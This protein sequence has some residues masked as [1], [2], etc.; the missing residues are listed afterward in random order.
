MIGEEQAWQLTARV[1][2]LS[3]PHSVEVALK[4]T[5]SE[6]TRF[7]NNTVHQNVSESDARVCV[8]IFHGQ[9]TGAAITNR[10]EPAGLAAAV[11]KA[12][13][14]ASHGTPDPHLPRMVRQ[15]APAA[16]HAFDPATAT[17][18]PDARAELVG[19]LC[20]Q[21]AGIGLRASGAFRVAAEE[22]AVATSEGTFAYHAGTAADFQTVVMGD[23]SSGWAHA[24]HWKATEIPVPDLGEEA[25]RKAVDGKGPRTFEPQST[26]VVLEPYA[27]ADLVMMLNFVG[28]GAQSVIEGQSWMVDRI[29][30]QAMS[31]QVS[32]WDDGRDSEGLPLAFDFEGVPKQRVD[33]VRAGVVQGP[34]YDRKTANRLGAASTGHALSPFL[35]ALVR[36][37]GPLALNLRMAVGE[38]TTEELIASTEHGLYITRFHYTR[39]VHPRDCVV[40]GMTRDGVFVI[41]DGRLAYP[42]K[43]LRFTQSYVS[44]LN[45]VERIGAETRLLADDFIG[46]SVRAPAIKLKSFRF[47]GATA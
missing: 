36:G 31:E 30:K 33:I 35:P 25:I 32:I 28:M 38:S 45:E 46:M 3:G 27:T 23:G 21:A 29:G 13:E 19:G 24:A 2:E 12:R 4:G 7:A 34:V 44:A 10:L 5:A 18:S 15:P 9:R 17:H 20:R 37:Y 47:T 42:I 11:Q 14:F 8:R 1:L 6:L 26:T 40:T 41:E 43:D 39:T 16:L 22:L